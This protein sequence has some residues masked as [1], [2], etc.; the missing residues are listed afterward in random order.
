M[1]FYE[2]YNLWVYYNLENKSFRLFMLN[3]KINK[4]GYY[5]FYLF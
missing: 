4:R 3:A 5:G 1:D 2:M